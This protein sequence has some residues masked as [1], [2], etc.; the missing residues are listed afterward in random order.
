MTTAA[1]G[2]GQLI[3][4]CEGGLVVPLG[5]TQAMAAAI[6]T[7]VTDHDAR[8]RASERGRKHV[9]ANYGLDA[10]AHR[11]QAILHEAEGHRH[12]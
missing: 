1:G 12:G 8:Q 9:V 11:F 5:D 7:L 6:T 2:S 4:D 10:L 3:Q